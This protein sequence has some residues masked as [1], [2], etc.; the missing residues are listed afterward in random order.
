[1]RPDNGQIAARLRGLLSGQGEPQALAARLRVDETALRMS[2][3]LV[4]PYPTLDVIAAVVREY[5]VDPSWLITGE[6]DSGSHRAAIEAGTA[7]L[8]AI[9][10]NVVHRVM[11]TPPYNLRIVR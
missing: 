6:Y 11:T 5:A 10:N 4:S 8:P 1:M 2:I 7:E 3:D 9:V